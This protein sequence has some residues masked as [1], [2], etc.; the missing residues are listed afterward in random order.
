LELN[1]VD[2]C[3]FRCDYC[4]FGRKIFFCLDVEEFVRG[5]DAAFERHPRQRL[6]KFSNTTD[7]PPFEPELDAI[8]P[9]IRRFSREPDRYLLLF[10]KSSNVAFLESLEH[11][12]RTI[13]SWS[14]TCETVS[15]QVDRGTATMVERIG[16]MQSAERAGY[17]VRARLSP[18]IPIRNWEKEYSCLLEQLFEK[19]SPDIVTLELLGWMEL[20]DLSALF[21]QGLLD[22]RAVR[23][24]EDSADQVRGMRWGPFTQETH[25]EV[26]RFLIEKVQ[27]LSPGTPV[28]VCHGTLATW[29]A[30][31]PLMRMTPDSYLCNCGPDSAPG[32]ALYGEWPG[33][34]QHGSSPV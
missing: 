4:G 20:E 21:Q 16:A 19:A 32:G 7:L 17:G 18:I 27:A 12:G 22:E 26:Y 6:F 14:L 8:P 11:G 34:P 25:E 9:M 28:S 5:L 1:L 29:R 13:I 15:R 30:L 33:D 3:V 2:G 10:T 31:G 24:A 23:A